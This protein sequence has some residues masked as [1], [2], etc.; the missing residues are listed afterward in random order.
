VRVRRVPALRE[1]QVEPV[2]G[3]VLLGWRWYGDEAPQVRVLR[4]TQ[5]LCESPTA[6]ERGEWGQEVVYEG[7]DR[8]YADGTAG[9]REDL[10]YTI[11]ARFRSGG[12]RRPVHVVVRAGGAE[13][14]ALGLRGA[15]GSAPVLLDGADG[16]LIGGRWVEILGTE[17]FTAATVVASKRDWAL[18]F[19]P[20]ATAGILFSYFAGLDPRVI[21]PVTVALVA[22][23]RVLEGRDA[24][25]RRFARSLAA[26]AVVAAFM[27][28]AALMFWYFAQVGGGASVAVASGAAIVYWAWPFAF[29]PAIMVVWGLA[30]LT[31]DGQGRPVR[32]APWVALGACAAVG[33]VWPVAALAVLLAVGMVLWVRAATRA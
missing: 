11:F 27:L 16:R 33:A 25:P 26:A 6:H 29:L 2:P 4:S 24:D 21:T 31:L 30:G 28:A 10:F 8:C 15:G 32:P 19:V 13:P 5:W 18:I 7:A 12:W 17:E 3:G 1:L 9:E 20:A 14:P 23:W 22:A